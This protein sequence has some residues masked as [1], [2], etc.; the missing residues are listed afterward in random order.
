[1]LRNYGQS[2]QYAHDELG[3]NSRL[4]EVQAA[5]L[6]DALLPN[7]T[8]WTE[9]RREIAA[10]YRARIVHGE[11]RLLSPREAT[12]P[13][14]HLFPV[15]TRKRDGLREHLER[16]QI[17]SSIHYPRIIPDQKAMNAERGLFEI[18]AEPANARRLARSE[19][20]LPIHPFLRD[21]ELEQVIIACNGFV[22]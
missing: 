1:M 13:A 22:P 2:S 21:D 5:I 3:L 6:S 7:L 18:A 10:R 19:L 16:E 9:R 20:S 12:K 8:L 4:D 11:L 15:F 14:W 17:R